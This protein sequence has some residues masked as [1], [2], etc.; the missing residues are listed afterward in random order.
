MAPYPTGP[1]LAVSHEASPIAS[2]CIEAPAR[3]GRCT[4]PLRRTGG[5][6]AEEIRVLLMSP[7]A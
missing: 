1:P 5:A 7:L 3:R 4:D 6:V 2:E